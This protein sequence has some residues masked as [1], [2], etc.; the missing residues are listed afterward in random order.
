MSFA[1]L[2]RFADRPSWLTR[3][4]TP[5]QR[6]WIAVAAAFAAGLMPPAA[7]G[8]LATLA[9]VVALGVWSAR[10]PAGV[11]V[12]RVAHASPFFLLPALALPFSFPGPTALQVGPLGLS[13]PGL[14]KAGEILIRASLAVTAVTV[15]ISV[16]RAADLLNALEGLPLPGLVKSSLALGYRYVYVLNDELERT[17]RALRSR[18]GGLAAARLWRA[19]ATALAH[20]FLRAHARSARIHAAML[21]RGYR[22]QFPILRAGRPTGR[23]WTAAILGLIAVVWL[24]GL[25]EATT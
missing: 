4:T 17:T 19:R 21:S 13:G 3:R 10:I 18:A 15:V 6:L 9:I 1:H 23:G 25:I 20:L 11:L 12:R 16:T 24:A 2:D 22:G 14:I 7:W 5:G 8:A